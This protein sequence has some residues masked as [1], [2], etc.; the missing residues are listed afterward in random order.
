[1]VE[2]RVDEGWKKEARERQEEGGEEAAG[3]PRAAKADFLSLLSGLAAQTLMQLGELENP[4]AGERKMDLDAAKY[5]ID[6]LGVLK[7]KT[8]GNLTDEEA[9]YIDS[10]LYDLRMRYV[11]ACGI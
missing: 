8:K 9:R 1:M 4:I 11:K 6:L 7:E 3:A 2:K 10:M 5:S